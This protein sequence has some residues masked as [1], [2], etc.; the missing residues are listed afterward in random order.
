MFNHPTEK[1]S[2]YGGN[3]MFNNTDNLNDQEYIEALMMD[4][5]DGTLSRSGKRE[6][7]N[8]LSSNP[9][10]AE[11]LA[12][13]Q[14]VDS[15]FAEPQMIEPPTAFVENTMAH[16]PNLTVRKWTTGL[17]G[18][19]VIIL[20][21]APLALITFLFSNMPAQTVILELTEAIISGAAQLV[22]GL[23]DYAS[24]QP[25]TLAVPAV[26]F[27]SIFLWYAL[28]RRMVGSLTPVRG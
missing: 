24:N 13:M 11:E 27:S 6:L 2:R 14:A 9:S 23:I 25:V 28:Y 15:L 26:M 17:L 18:A 4:A 19:L 22:A 3:E 8:Y 1:P 21:L 12:A 7:D 16:L 10:M 20:G 5:I